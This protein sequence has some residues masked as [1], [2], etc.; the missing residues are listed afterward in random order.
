[1]D[2]AGTILVNIDIAYQVADDGSGTAKTIELKV[3]GTVVKSYITSAISEQGTINA[4]AAVTGLASGVHAVTVVL[5]AS[6]GYSAGGSL[7]AKGYAL[8]VYR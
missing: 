7:S 8:G 6:A 4:T 5:S 1:L 3:G 2:V